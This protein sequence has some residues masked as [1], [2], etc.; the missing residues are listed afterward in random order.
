[1]LL[2][3]AYFLREKNLGDD[4]YLRRVRNLFL[5]VIAIYGGLATY[6]LVMGIFFNSYIGFSSRIIFIV[7]IVVGL[8]V[9]YAIS[10]IEKNYQLAKGERDKIQAR[11]ELGQAVQELLLP[12]NRDGRFGDKDYRFYFEPA[13]NMAVDWL[14]N[15]NFKE[16]EL[17]L[18]IGDVTGKGPQAALAVSA[19]A[20][21]IEEC[22]EREFSMDESIQAIHQR[23]FKLFKGKVG[24][25]MNLFMHY[26]F[27]LWV[28]RTFPAN[29]WCRYADDGAPRMRGR[30]S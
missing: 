7:C 12:E 30:R 9:F 26:A 28:D 29:P 17:R 2:I 11:L 15:W 14:T 8:V 21:V 16:K 23:L 19:I 6:E 18:F 27:D 22:K 1:M 20:S 10:L 13:E 3:A 4:T 24:T 25:L 5:F